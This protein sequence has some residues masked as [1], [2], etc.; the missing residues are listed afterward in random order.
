MHDA[1]DGSARGLRR[2][3]HSALIPLAR[4]RVGH[5]P[6]AS[7]VPARGVLGAEPAG[8]DGPPW[9]SGGGDT[10]QP[11]LLAIG[12]AMLATKHVR[13][14]CGH[15]LGGS[16]LVVSSTRST[17]AAGGL[18]GGVPAGRRLRPGGAWR[19][20]RDRGYPHRG[21]VLVR[22]MLGNPASGRGQEPSLH[23]PGADPPGLLPV[24]L[25]TRPGLVLLLPCARRSR[26][27][28]AGHPDVAAGPGAQPP[29]PP[30]R[31]PHLLD[32]P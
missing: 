4:A 10:A 32:P 18:T 2:P 9:L 13:L 11:L 30:A 1:A 19:P 22:H 8:H 3:G 17:A 21:L 14:G 15:A 28:P 16:R 7:T 23:R 12:Q 25:G 27:Y 31:Y 5:P 24:P 26:L 20:E 6:V 29:A